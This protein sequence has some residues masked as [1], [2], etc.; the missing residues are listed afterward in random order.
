MTIAEAFGA[1]LKEHRKNLNI[2]QEELAHRCDLDRT[3]ISLLERGKRSPT[4][5]TIFKVS[6]N[7]NSSPSEFIKKIE[8]LHN[9]N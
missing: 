9:S 5:E 2:S 7:L 8:D 3:F 4:I 6:T 1:I